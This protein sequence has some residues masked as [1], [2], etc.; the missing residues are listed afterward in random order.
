MA[1]FRG[2]SGLRTMERFLNLRRSF[3]EAAVIGLL[4][5]SALFLPPLDLAA[6]ANLR[7]YDLWSRLGS[8][9]SATDIVL[10]HL[11]DPSLLTPL[12]KAAND[13]HAKLLITTLPAP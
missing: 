13:R 2:R 4:A 8:E 1:Y 11:E 5:T 3:V 9:S 10:V 12:A 7:I 6:R